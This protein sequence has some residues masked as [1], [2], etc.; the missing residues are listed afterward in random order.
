MVFIWVPALKILIYLYFVYRTELLST[1]AGPWLL[2]CTVNC[3]Y[4][5]V[6]WYGTRVEPVI[7]EARA[8]YYREKVWEEAVVEKGQ[9]MAEV[10]GLNLLV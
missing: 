10:V 5:L 8:V 7:E 9:V 3:L 6:A 2:F 1:I 4:I